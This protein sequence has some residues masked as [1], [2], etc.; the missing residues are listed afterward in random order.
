MKNAVFSCLGLGDGLLT[1]ILSNNLR[2]NGLDVI[3]FHPQLSQLQR[4]FPQLPIEPFP[5]LEV[6]EGFDRF[7]IFYEKSPW[8]LSILKRCLERY[9][10]KTVV[11]N[12]IATPHRDYPYWE[13]GQF[14]G[15]Q[16]FVTNLYT[17]CKTLLR[18]PYSTRSNGVV[19]PAG[20]SS[21]C[22]ASRVLLHPTSSKEEKNWPKEKFLH[23]ARRLREAGFDPLFILSPRERDLWPEVEA[24]LFETLDVLAAYV[25]ESAFFIGNDS[26]IGHLASCLGL[27]T[28]TICS[29]KRSGD[30]W[31]PDWSP[32]TILYPPSW[33]PNL[34]GMRWRDRHWKR[35]ISVRSVLSHF[36]RLHDRFSDIQGE[37][38]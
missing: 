36:Q 5:S 15:S 22:A 33:M 2:I 31:R 11:L 21:R 17:F 34:K 23:L 3:T 27:P 16:T 24:P 6:L 38:L 26:G 10:H 25:Y 13:E 9:R 28:L 12:P 30:F 35:L 1:L 20:L 14:D 29:T 8:M 37:S 7:F 4:W 18:L 19:I 32:G